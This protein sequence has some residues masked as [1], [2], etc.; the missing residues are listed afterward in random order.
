MGRSVHCVGCPKRGTEDNSLDNS[1][2]DG[3]N[4]TLETLVCSLPLAKRL[5]ELGVKQKSCFWWSDHTYQ[6]TLWNES[7]LLDEVSKMQDDWTFCANAYSAFT[8]SELGEMLPTYINNG[9]E[10]LFLYIYP[11]N[12]KCWRVC[13]RMWGDNRGWQIEKEFSEADVRA[14]MLIHLIEKGLWKP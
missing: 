7:A 13:Y 14:K 9:I 11:D 8:A 10:R 3:N 2:A 6:S 4:M 12:E 1:D 5:K